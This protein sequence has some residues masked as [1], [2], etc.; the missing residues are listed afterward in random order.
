MDESCR[1][2]ASNGRVLWRHMT[3][4]RWDLPLLISNGWGS[5][6]FKASNRFS[7]IKK[8]GNFV[9]KVLDEAFRNQTSREKPHLLLLLQ[10]PVT[11]LLYTSADR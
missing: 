1:Y 5:P 8:V 6:L 3:T 11:S 7:A 4:N 2:M 9:A 10:K